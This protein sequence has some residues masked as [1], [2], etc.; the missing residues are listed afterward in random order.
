MGR[1]VLF[2]LRAAGLALAVALGVVGSLPAAISVTL[3]DPQNDT[4]GTGSPQLDI[5][6]LRVDAVSNTHLKF[7]LS[8]YTPISPPSLAGA[9]ALYG[10]ILID[11]DNDADMASVLEQL[12]TDPSLDLALNGVEYFI[13]LSSESSTLG[14]V[15]V[16]DTSTNAPVATPSIT[17][18]PG[19]TFFDVFVTLSRT[20]IGIP[21]NTDVDIRFGAIV[22]TANESTDVVPNIP[23]PA[24]A[25][26]TG[27]LLGLAGLA[28]WRGRRQGR[29]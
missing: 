17:Y 14:L 13:D 6:E 4:F 28:R 29:S 11:I 21:N 15:D 5:K 7:T 8:F 19:P 12:I 1:S 24:S 18:S 22:G 23:E 25:L 20:N 26:L 10:M 27:A 3:S 2:G 9:N 16:V